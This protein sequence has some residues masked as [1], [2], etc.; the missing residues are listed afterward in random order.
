[1]DYPHEIQARVWNIAA[2][3]VLAH[4]ECRVVAGGESTEQ[5]KTELAGPVRAW[6]LETRE[7]HAL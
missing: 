6:S 4:D 1:M 5:K 2:A 3:V 7:G